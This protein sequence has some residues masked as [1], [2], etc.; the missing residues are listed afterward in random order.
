MEINA[1]K[2]LIAR[3]RAGLGSDQSSGIG[4]LAEKLVH[5]TLKYYFESD[6]SKHEVAFC[7][8]VADVLNEEG[9]IEIQT[10]SFNKL[11]PKLEKFLPNSPVTIICPVVEHKRICRIDPDSGECFSS[12]KSSKCGKVYEVLCELYMIK[13]FIP[14]DNLRISVVMLDVEE[15]RMQKRSIKVGRHRTSKINSIPTSLNNIIELSEMSD[16]AI[17]MPPGLP[18][19]FSATEFEKITKLKGMKSHSSLM[20]LLH[21][22]L[23]SREKRGGRAFTYTVC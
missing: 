13:D 19:E 1:D 8:S 10:R 5:R 11:V 17:L 7:G 6:E 22:G 23:V 12:R 14:N 15:T 2:F 9:V 20:M 3:A 21:L 18:K 16:Y 4:C